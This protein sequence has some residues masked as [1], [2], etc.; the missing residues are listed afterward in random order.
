MVFKLAALTMFKNEGHIINEWL[1]VNNTVGGIEHFYLIDNES[2]DEYTIDEDLKDKVTIY[3]EPGLVKRYTAHSQE[4][5]YE[6]HYPKMRH[7]TEWVIV[8]DMDEFLYHRGKTTVLKELDN[9]P[10]QVRSLSV[11]WLEYLGDGLLMDPQCKVHTYQLCHPEHLILSDAKSELAGK[12]ISRTSTTNKVHTHHSFGS[13]RGITQKMRPSDDKICINHYRFQA[14]EYNLGIKELRGGGNQKARYSVSADLFG[15]LI[16]KDLDVRCDTKLADC[17]NAAGLNAEVLCT[18]SAPNVN[19]YPTSSWVTK[20][21]HQLDNITTLSTPCY[22]LSALRERHTA[23]FA[24]MTNAVEPKQ[25]ETRSVRESSIDEITP[26]NIFVASQKEIPEAILDEWQDS[27]PG[28]IIKVYSITEMTEELKFEFEDDVKVAYNAL[29][30]LFR[31]HVL[32]TYG[33]FWI[34]LDLKP[35]NVTQLCNTPLQIFNYKHN[36]ISYKCMGS[37][38]KHPLIKEVYTKTKNAVLN[39]RDTGPSLMQESASYCFDIIFKNG[40]ANPVDIGDKLR[41]IHGTAQYLQLV[42]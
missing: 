9:L 20:L 36:N 34:D 3:I 31:M 28:A 38:A 33:G 16:H 5:V 39:R 14:Y 4:A 41:G 27:N 21:K 26:M 25:V 15:Q 8:M 1:R 18:R 12:M 35:F 13:G 23:I 19:V 32:Y 17:C 37:V 2:T 22:T 7:T 10:P 42:I 29:V 24:F 11:C 40:R 6:K 30:D